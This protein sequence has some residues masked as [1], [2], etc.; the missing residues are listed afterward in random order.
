M[1]STARLIRNGTALLQDRVPLAGNRLVL[2]V[3]SSTLCSPCPLTLQRD[4]AQL[5]RP[6]LPKYTRKL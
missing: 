1:Q 3:F 4:I 2:T 6:G 5:N